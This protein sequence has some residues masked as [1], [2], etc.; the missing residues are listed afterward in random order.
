MNNLELADILQNSENTLDGIEGALMRMAESANQYD[1][2]SFL[3]DA[4]LFSWLASCIHDV[5]ENIDGVAE[6]LI[7]KNNED[8]PA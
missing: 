7:N 2:H 5:S 6:E 3:T 4:P 8:N 1:T